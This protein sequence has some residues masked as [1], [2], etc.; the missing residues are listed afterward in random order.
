M[1]PHALAQD[2]DGNFYLMPATKV[3]RFDELIEV[4]KTMGLDH[5]DRLDRELAK[6]DEYRVDLAKLRVLK[7]SV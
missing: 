3:P 1:T 5:D 7:W 4:E 6:Y 2:N